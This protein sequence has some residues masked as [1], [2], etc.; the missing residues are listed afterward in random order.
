MARSV[1]DTFIRLPSGMCKIEGKTWKESYS[2]MKQKFL[3][4]FKVHTVIVMNAWQP[5]ALP[6]QFLFGLG[7]GMPSRD[8]GCCVHSATVL[9]EPVCT[10]DAVY[11]GVD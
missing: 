10:M 8:F 2:E 6:S 4:T 11:C 3:I 5:L 9:V 7:M 1:S